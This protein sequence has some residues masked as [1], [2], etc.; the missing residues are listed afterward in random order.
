MYILFENSYTNAT[1]TAKKVN[2]ITLK[3]KINQITE[4]L[5]PRNLNNSYVLEYEY[6]NNYK[7]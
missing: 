6:E 5:L 7:Y 3:I 1:Y 4:A 2:K